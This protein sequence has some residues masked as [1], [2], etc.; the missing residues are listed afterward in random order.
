MLCG[1]RLYS[2]CDTTHR[3]TLLTTPPRRHPGLEPYK[4]DK[5]MRMYTIL[6]YF[7]VR[8]SYLI[9]FFIVGLESAGHAVR[10]VISCNSGADVR[11]TVRPV[12]SV[13]YFC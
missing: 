9:S 1:N 12:Y 11:F 5:V 4:D 7:L 13:R 8:M 6:F 3:R 10:K 2:S